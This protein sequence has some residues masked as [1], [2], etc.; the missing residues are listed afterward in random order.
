MWL[1]LTDGTKRDHLLQSNDGK[2]TPATSSAL[3]TVS[4]SSEAGKATGKYV[5]SV[6]E[7]LHRALGVHA[8]VLVAYQDESGAVK[9][10]E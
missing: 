9:I 4:L 6:L 1:S 10:S 8:L 5:H 3:L 2:S 7:Q